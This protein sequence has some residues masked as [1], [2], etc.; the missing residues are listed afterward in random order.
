MT[1]SPAHD[2]PDL[3]FPGRRLF[4]DTVDDAVRSG[5]RHAVTG[6]LRNALCGLIRNPD[7]RLPACVHAPVQERYA[8]RE[9][10]RSPEHGYSVVAMTWGPGQGTPLHDHSGLWC[11]EGIWLGE[12][13]ITQYELLERAGDHYRFRAAGGVRAGIGSAGSL[14]PPHEYHTIHNPSSDRIA[15]S[16]HIYQAEMSGCRRFVPRTGEWF[17]AE[18]A[19]LASDRAA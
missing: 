14:I 19:A 3:D 2:W 11:V 12:L 1:G 6:T 8:R 4:L 10:Y 17:I 7:I 9:L 13:E 18:H 5:D 16:L 15:I